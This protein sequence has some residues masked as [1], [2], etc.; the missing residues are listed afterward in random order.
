MRDLQT[1]I[2]ELHHTL[3]HGDLRGIKVLTME[4]VARIFRVDHHTINRWV[5]SG[6]IYERSFFFTPGR[7]YRFFEVYIRLAMVEGGMT[8]SECDLYIRKART[9]VR[10]LMKHKNSRTSGFP[11]RR[12]TESGQREAAA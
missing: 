3:R 11:N 9:D 7:H 12:R 4:E 8:E 10:D 5:A 6:K 1:E 2:K